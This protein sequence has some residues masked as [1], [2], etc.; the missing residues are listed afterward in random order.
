[1]VSATVAGCLAA[2]VNSDEL[3]RIKQE[4]EFSPDIALIALI[5]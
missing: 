4:S 5:R 2:P 1:M 3:L